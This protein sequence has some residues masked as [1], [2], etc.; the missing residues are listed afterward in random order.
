MKPRAKASRR[1]SLDS[2]LL[3]SLTSHFEP[4]LIALDEAQVARFFLCRR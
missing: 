3:D 4:E 1:F 2:R